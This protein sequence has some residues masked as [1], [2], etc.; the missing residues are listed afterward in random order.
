MFNAVLVNRRERSKARN[1]TPSLQRKNV[2]E[3][4]D[5]KNFSGNKVANNADRRGCCNEN[6]IRRPDETNGVV[7]RGSSAAAD[8]QKTVPHKKQG[9]NS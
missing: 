5:L 3:L 9:R 7:Y 8:S 6:T 1:T 4:G 2:V